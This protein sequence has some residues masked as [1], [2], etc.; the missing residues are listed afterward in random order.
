MVKLNTQTINYQHSKLYYYASTLQDYSVNNEEQRRKQT[1]PSP[2]HLCGFCKHRKIAREIAE[3]S[4]LSTGDVKNSIDN[5]VTVLTRH[6]QSSEVVTLDGFGTFRV[7]MK[8]RGKGVK[9]KEE[10][11]ASQ[12]SLQ[13]H[14]T[15]ASTR[16]SDRTVAT[17]SLV[18][19]VKCVLYNPEPTGSGNGS[20]G[21]N[22]DG[23]DGGL[24]E[25][26]LG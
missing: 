14:F 16:N 19:G 11:S 12:A 8:S 20:G 17:R 18:T 2:H 24:D 10:V 1:I 22:S 9:N 13:I 26:P 23:G 3:Y 7:V 15:P 6:L 25:N 5:L 4:S 21:G